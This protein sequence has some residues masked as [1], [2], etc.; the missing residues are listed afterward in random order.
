MAMIRIQIEDFSIEE[1]LERLRRGRRDI[2][3]VASFVGLVRDVNEQAGVGEMRLEHY[4]GMA[5]R[6]LQGIVDEASERWDLTD[7]V[8]I[9]RVGT[10]RP[11]DRIVL[12][13]TASRHRRDALEAC[14]YIIDSL[15]VRGPFWKKENTASGSRWVAARA[16]D[17]EAAEQWDRD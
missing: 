2:G 15:K 1:E 3:A 4:P 7:T 5:E 10:L 6:I 14:A 12:V 13:A 8:V 16:S 9:H 17:A 11:A